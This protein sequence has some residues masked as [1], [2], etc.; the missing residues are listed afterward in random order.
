MSAT[1]KP[2]S[3]T[4]HQ[5]RFT[6]YIRDPD[7]ASVPE[8]IEKRRIDL[9]R[10]LMFNNVESLLS[11]SFPVLR[12]IT[13]EEIWSDMVEDFFSRHRCKT[14]Y[15][16]EIPEEFLEYLQNE[17]GERKEDFPFLL[18]LAHYEWVEL[19]LALA[20][21]EQ[22]AHGRGALSAEA[23]KHKYRVS[24]LAWPL[25]YRYPVHKISTSFKPQQ[26]PDDPTYVVAYRNPED[27]VKFTEINGVTYRFLQILDATAD[28]T[29]EDCLIGISKELLYLDRNKI[30]EFGRETLQSLWIR[31]IVYCR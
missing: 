1:V 9:Y 8:D 24:D 15:F 2:A 18:E 4:E 10:E 28:K 12:R 5:Y 11:N 25:V 23:L 26:P 31:G 3:F 17:R 30:I 16:S 19:A 14:P 21:D 29:A 22:P 20:V 13:S 27:Q 6:A 7:R